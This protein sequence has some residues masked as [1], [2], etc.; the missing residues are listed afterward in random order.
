MTIYTNLFTP[1]NSVTAWIPLQATPLEMGPLSFCVGSH[2]IMANRDL[3]ISDDSEEKIDRSL[4]NYPK[5]VS[6]FDLGEVSF[7]R[8]W[9]FHRAEPNRT[10]R[11]RGV[12]T[13][14]YL[15]DGMIL[16]E[17]KNSNQQADWDRWMP[18]SRVGEPIDTPLNPVIYNRNT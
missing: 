5:D 4:R 10:D 11:M 9:T 13:I 18:G 6:A 3:E 7:H 17:P 1:P 12:M 14:I 8:G 2:R 15:E 16:A